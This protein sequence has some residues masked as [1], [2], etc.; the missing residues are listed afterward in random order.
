MTKV[1]AA[2][3]PDA[4][5]LGHL[6]IA[7]HSRVRRVVDDA[8]T[9]SGVSLSRTIVLKLLA[10]L[11]PVNQAALATELGFAPRSITDL[12]D[13]LERDGL[14]RRVDNPADRRSRLVQ[15]TDTGSVAL[16]SALKVK[17][18]L[19]EEIFS[20]LDPPSRAALFTLLSTVHASLSPL[21]GDLDVR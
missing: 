4:E 10:S 5:D 19:F 9:T 16:E 17:C 11:G 2:A 20:V 13:G 15:I 21:P 7:L 12:V 3:P 18:D 14:A 6:Y 1:A 8:M